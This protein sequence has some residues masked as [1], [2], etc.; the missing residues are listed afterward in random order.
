MSLVPRVSPDVS[1]ELGR[2]LGLQ[3]IHSLKAMGQLKADWAVPA[4]NLTVEA[5]KARDVA[6]YRQ[7]QHEQR[8]C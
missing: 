1:A 6:R 3:L 8:T 4:R 2:G 5:K 7:I